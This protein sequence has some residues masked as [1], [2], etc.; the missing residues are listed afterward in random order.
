MRMLKYGDKPEIPPDF[1]TLCGHKCRNDIRSG[2]N[3]FPLGTPLYNS[4]NIN[5]IRLHSRGA[6]TANHIDTVR[7]APYNQA[8][9]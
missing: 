7:C 4:L 2:S 6:P 9:H 1:L 8:S 5:K 3:K